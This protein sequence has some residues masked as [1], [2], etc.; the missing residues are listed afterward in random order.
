MLTP[1][2]VIL[3]QVT[4]FLVE[5]PNNDREVRKLVVGSGTCNDIPFE[6]TAI[7]DPDFSTTLDLFR[8]DGC[9]FS[10][11]EFQSI[12][13]RIKMATPMETFDRRG[14]PEAKGYEYFYDQMCEK[15]HG[16]KIYLRV[17]F[18]RKDEA[19][20]LGAEW[21]SAAKKWFAFTDSPHLRRLEECFRRD[22]S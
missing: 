18:N 6:A 11:M 1:N 16:K 5:Y 14:D 12:Q 4:H 2:I 17:P 15:Y 9:R 3:N 8:G 21:D 7:N 13:R 10:K 20:G 22:E 19:K